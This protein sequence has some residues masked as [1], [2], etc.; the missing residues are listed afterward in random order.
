MNN[1]DWLEKR[2]NVRATISSKVKIKLI[3]NDIAHKLTLPKKSVSKKTSRPLLK[4]DLAIGKSRNSDLFAMS[5]LPSSFDDTTNPVIPYLV[6]SIFL[7]NDK[8][9]KIIDLLEDNKGEKGYHIT[10]L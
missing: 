9:D 8:R 7:L 4:K 5:D 1:N 2:D 3:D 6:D 10:F